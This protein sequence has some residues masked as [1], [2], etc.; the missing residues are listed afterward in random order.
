MNLVRTLPSRD[1]EA[2]WR[3]AF[4]RTKVKAQLIKVLSVERL[5]G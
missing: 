1:Q 2:G 4:T 3:T 5:F